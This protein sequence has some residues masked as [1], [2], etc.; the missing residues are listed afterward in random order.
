MKNRNLA[1]VGAGNW[2]K[3]L[4]RNFFELGCLHSICDMDEALLARYRDLYKPLNTTSS[5]QSILDNPEI[6]LVA[7]ATPIATHY[8]LVKM[9]LLA[10]KDVYVEKPLCIDV[11]HAHELVDLATST[12]RILMVGHILQYHP[13]INHLQELVSKGTIGDI[14]KVSAKRHIP[15]SPQ[16]NDHIIWDLAP[17]DLS[18][19][20]SLIPHKPDFINVLSVTNPKKVID[21]AEVSIKFDSLPSNSFIDV[22]RLH[23]VKEQKL[24]VEG[25]KGTLIFDDT[26]PW[27]EK[28][29]H[30]QSQQHISVEQSEP[31]R[32]E[33][34]HFLDCCVSRASPKTN[35][36]EAI[37]VVQILQTVQNLILKDN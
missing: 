30:L 31:L 5:F 20:L 26:K 32:N 29:F 7:I 24:I 1:L 19:I 15:H 37:P 8:P 34:R 3:N 28:L 6:S 21:Q 12:K 33:C 36:E 2:G 18:V 16:V 11:D 9:A 23:S 17:H 22:S 27:N 25:S 35:G 14:L 13:M 10:G 4:A